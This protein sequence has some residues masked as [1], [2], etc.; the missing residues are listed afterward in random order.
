MT[1]LN[2]ISEYNK[3]L[4]AQYDAHL[5]SLGELIVKPELFTDGTRTSKL[6]VNLKKIKE[7]RDAVKEINENSQKNEST[8][9][10]EIKNII[11]LANLSVETI[12]KQ[13]SSFLSAVNTGLNAATDYESKLRYVINYLAKE[14]TLK[15]L[16]QLYVYA[17]NLG[18]TQGQT[19]SCGMITE[20][21]DAL[22]ESM[23]KIKNQGN[24]FEQ[25]LQGEVQAVQREFT[26]VK[27][28]TNVSPTNAKGNNV[29]DEVIRTLPQQSYSTKL[30]K[31]Y[32]AANQM[33][34]RYASA[35][36]TSSSIIK[37][38]KTKISKLQSQIDNTY[39]LVSSSVPLLTQFSQNP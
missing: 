39:E 35:V 4:D 24:E 26:N 7:V 33:S 20:M 28:N 3:L 2:L 1:D 32:T 17:T 21:L 9:S 19:E 36:K 14:N 16:F 30:N 13:I 15:V 11:T 37:E 23:D 25:T 27:L 6:E 10:D 38:L 34:Q 5:K 12:K 8:K 31:L 18:A 22:S 29:P